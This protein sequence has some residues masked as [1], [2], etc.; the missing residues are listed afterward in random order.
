MRNRLTI[1]S[2]AF[3]LCGPAVHARTISLPA[4][5]PA[6]RFEVPK[7][8]TME[9]IDRGV[10]LES[11]D[12][13]ATLVLEITPAEKLDSLVKEN[14]EWLKKDQKVVFD[15]DTQSSENPGFGDDTNWEYVSWQVNQADWGKGR[16]ILATFHPNSTQIFMVTYWVTT[17]GE[18]LYGDA[19]KKL[20]ASVES[21][22][23][24]ANSAEAPA[25]GAFGSGPKSRIAST[26]TAAPPAN[27]APTGG[28][29]SGPS[30]RATLAPATD[31]PSS[32]DSSSDADPSLLIGMWLGNKYISFYED[33]RYGLQKWEGAPIDDK[34]RRWSLKGNKITWVT[35]DDTFTETIVT[36]TRKKLV[37]KDAEGNLETYKRIGD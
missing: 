19:M 29:G 17:K 22:T 28:F 5:K 24:A 4:T 21:T 10:S 7:G 25:A 32:A 31:A 27:P 9:E 1:L 11:P 36:L 26:E 23:P 13:E 20:F 37:I 16:V 35:P 12:K 33:G 14:V 34:G 18:K 6:V 2:L 3:T 15:R 30:S 8:W